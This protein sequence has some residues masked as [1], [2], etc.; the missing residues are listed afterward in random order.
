MSFQQFRTS[1]LPAILTCVI[2]VLLAVGAWLLHRSAS[3]PGDAAP[4]E[5]VVLAVPTQVGS[6]PVFVAQG[7]QFFA[8][9]RVALTIQPF[10][11]GKQAL[12]SLLQGKA[13]L[14]V[15]ADT[16]FMFA[17]MQGKKIVTV[18]TIFG[19]RKT[20]A[21]AVRKDRG[22]TRPEDLAGKTIGTVFGTNAQYFLDTLLLAHSVDKASVKVVDVKPGGLLEAL[23]SG[24]LD[25]VTVWHPDLA[26]IEGRSSQTAATLYGPELFVYRFLLVGTSDYVAAHPETVRRVLVA[27]RD[28]IGA[29]RSEPAQSRVVIGRAIGLNPELIA[30]SF[31]PN[32]F[33]LALDQTLLLALSDQTRWAMK[34]GLVPQGAVPNYLDFIRQEPLGAVLP[35]AVKIIK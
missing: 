13:D 15:V 31:D 1:R 26:R 19:S 27:L 5:E 4:R 7:R 20:M 10:A 21:V 25:A 28:G 11:L 6:G 12:E 33:Y 23:E 35:E 9:Q 22:I 32:D 30:Q 29:I 14:A 16:P 8:Q 18:S 24:Q 2:V 3:K 34:R 17:V